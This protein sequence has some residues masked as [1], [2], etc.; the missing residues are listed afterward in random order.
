MLKRWIAALLVL[1]LLPCWAVAEEPNHARNWYEIFV[2][3]YKDSDGD[4]I[5]DLPGVL[6]SLDYLED[7]GYNG[8]WLMPIAPSPSYHKYDVTDY[9]SVD[10]QYGTVEDLCALVQACHERG[11]ELILDLVVNHTSSEHPWFL[12]AC[13]ALRSGD[14]ENPY[15]GYY[16]FT[17]TAADGYVQLS[18]TDWYYEER[19]SGGGMPDLNLDNEAVRTE[20]RGIM[21]FWLNTCGVDGFRLDAVTS[22][23]TGDTDRNVAFLA[24]LKQTAEA[25]KPGS[26]L[27]G[28]CWSDLRT[29]A[30]YY[31]SG[32]D[33]FF[34]F[35]AAQAE[36]WIAKLVRSKKGGTNYAK[37]LQQL[38]DNLSGRLIAPFIGNHDTG[39]A[40]GVLQ[41]RTDTA[42]AKFAEGLVNMLGGAVFTYY[43]EE[44]GMVG[45][46]TDPDKRLGMY[47]SDDDIT[48]P[49]P[50]ATTVEYAY[51]SVAEQQADP[52]SLLNYC[53]AL[54][55][56]R[57][58]VPVIASGANETLLAEE[59]LVLLRRTGG[60][61]TAYIAINFSRNEAQQVALPS[62][63]LT[64]AAD[65]EVDTAQATLA[66]DTLTL[67]GWG[68]AV[69]TE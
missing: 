59:T 9:L 38:E 46:A 31:E 54:N 34:L 15:I 25:L 53:K 56:A 22:Y 58:Q 24:W 57:L 30:S 68:I 28:E 21:D 50:G 36:G 48:T 8:L 11:M 23:Y 55:H 19:F 13:E 51:P 3:S 52:A 39:R 45:S 41:A 10:P 66:G 67:P 6:E 18:G 26:Y 1:V 17:Q 62:S 47:W 42:K 20:I 64:L 5:G 37:Y 7:M 14:P 61:S 29:I 65:L 44:I 49:P 27:V 40:V 2:Y 12:A 69:L 32:V 33:S 35:P 43:G 63:G 4:G 60:D 16:H